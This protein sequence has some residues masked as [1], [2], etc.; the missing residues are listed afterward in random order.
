VIVWVAKEK[1]TGRRA[2]AV[3]RGP[4]LGLWG[5]RI[6]IKTNIEHR[7][8]NIEHPTSNIEAEKDL[9]PLYLDVG[10]SMLD[11]GCSHSMNFARSTYADHPVPPV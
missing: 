3:C 8:S 10:C 6:G 11:V 2:V 7:T 1:R 5:C 9:P 4:F